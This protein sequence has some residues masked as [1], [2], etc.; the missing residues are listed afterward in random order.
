M[1]GCIS[2]LISFYYISGRG[3]PNVIKQ[4]TNN[5]TPLQETDIPDMNDAK[6][7]YEQAYTGQLTDPHNFGIDPLISSEE[8]C[9]QREDDFNR[10]FNIQEIFGECVNERPQLF[11]NAILSQIHLTS[12]LSLNL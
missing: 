3:V 12:Q 4:R 2:G 7:I 11:Q 8:L 6:N 10:N 5:L 9:K 1:A